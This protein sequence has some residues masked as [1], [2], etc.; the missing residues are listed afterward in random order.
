MLKKLILFLGIVVSLA[1]CSSI[2]PLT[3]TNNKPVASSSVAQPVH[4]TSPAVTPK[5]DIK[6]LDEISVDPQTAAGLKEPAPSNLDSRKSTSDVDLY[7]N[8]NASV[9]K[10]SSLQIKY[11]ILLNT[12]V[13][14]LQNSRVLESVDE[15]YG[16]R[17]RMGGMS[18]SGVDCS[19]FVQAVY[20][21]AFATTVPRT[22][23]EQYKAS[24][25]I[26]AVD[27][28]E[29]DLV[30]FNTTGGVSHV[31][32]YL[33]NNKF[34][35]ASSSKGVTIS[36]LFEPYYLRRYIGAGRIEKAEPQNN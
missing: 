9:E 36:D 5:K 4:T 13:E 22:A 19:A 1:S 28:K 35:H 33:R 24:R 6:F 30:F 21:S 34:V 31:G 10:A 20:L 23:F 2:K 29:G 12:D 3:F 27:L 15:W 11:S 8:K 17:Y 7:M 32:M 16:T 14:E 25:I 18:K 26:S